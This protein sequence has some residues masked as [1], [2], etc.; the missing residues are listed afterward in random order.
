MP[1]LFFS[2]SAYAFLLL[3]VPSLVFSTSAY[4]F[5]LFEVPSLFW[6]TSAYA[7]LLFEVPFLVW[8]TCAYA[9]L[10]L[11]VPFHV[12][13]FALSSVYASFLILRQRLCLVA[14]ELWEF[15][16]AL[17][18]ESMKS[19]A[20]IIVPSCSSTM[21]NYSTIFITGVVSWL[22]FVPIGPV[23]LLSIRP[24]PFV[25]IL[26]SVESEPDWSFIIEWD[27]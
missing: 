1:S 14:S 24:F 13:S 4:A 8:F 2:T 16:S 15:T 27:H 17:T 19:F 10:L 12:L 23:D 26:N 20:R 3:E 22:A 25:L 9:L 21:V 5:L 18:D 6:S 7:F 11:L